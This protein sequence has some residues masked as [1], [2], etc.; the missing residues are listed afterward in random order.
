ME[1]TASARSSPWTFSRR[2]TTSRA[3]RCWSGMRSERGRVMT[4]LELILASASPRRRELIG[5]WGLSWRVAPADIDET[6]GKGEAPSEPAVRLGGSQAGV[7][8]GR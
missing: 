8:A 1:A 3:F 2:P 4:D 5:A 7:A 6:L